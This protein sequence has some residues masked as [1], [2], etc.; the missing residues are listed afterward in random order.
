MKRSLHMPISLRSLRF[1]ASRV[2]ALYLL[3]WA[4]FNSFELCLAMRK[5]LQE[6]CAKFSLKRG[7]FGLF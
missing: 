3:R 1:E 6:G 7:E 4:S 5:S 2:R